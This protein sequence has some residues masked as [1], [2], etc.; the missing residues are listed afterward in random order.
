MDYSELRKHRTLNHQFLWRDSNQALQLGR[1]FDLEWQNFLS[2]FAQ[3]P[4]SWNCHNRIVSAL[5][6]GS[7]PKIDN[8]SNVCD[9]KVLVI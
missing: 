7:Y 5:T 4:R 6:Y 1:S 3:G 9:L 8:T 2:D